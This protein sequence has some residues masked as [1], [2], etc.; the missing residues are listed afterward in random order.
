MIILENKEQ[1][2]IAY[3]RKEDILVIV[4]DKIDGDRDVTIVFKDS[5]SERDICIE[6]QRVSR[7]RSG[8]DNSDHILMIKEFYWVQKREFYIGP[9]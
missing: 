9:K 7:I 4:E 5:V 6:N 3:L 8:L 2:K 1:T